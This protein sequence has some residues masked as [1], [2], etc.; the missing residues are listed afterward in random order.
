VRIEGAGAEKTTLFMADGAAG[1]VINAPFGWVQISGLTIDGNESKR[2]GTVG[3]NIR[4]NGDHVLIEHVR[5]INSVSYG[6][7]IGQK[8]YAREVIVRD[9]EIVNAGADGIDVKNW[10]KRT[11]GI[12][13][14]NVTVR[15]FGRPDPALDPKLI[16]TTQDKR[17]AKA[18]V[19]LRGKCQVRG[20]TIIG[21]L[22]HR[23]G[24][25]FRF[26]EV[27]ADGSSASH[28]KVRGNKGQNRA[29]AISV[30]S[31]DI[32]LEDVDIADTTFAIV[33]VA[34]NLKVVRGKIESS[35]EAAVL[36]R[37]F[38]DSRPGQIEFQS[39]NFKGE[40]KFMFQ[41]VDAV[42]FDNCNFSECRSQI[43]QALAQDT[44]IVLKGCRFDSA[45]S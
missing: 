40:A 14:E 19:D 34:P 43:Q 12:V 39:I 25:R 42:N 44:R 26:G 27:G 33:V 31:S 13:I 36:A 5:C 23:D 37:A 45:C 2:R 35:A 24:L 3:H 32:R 41:D 8:H 21:I 16:G 29:T 15:G 38:R 4:V 6:I 18:A 11:E 1:H 10:L 17:G 9:V 20:L 28:I 30:G 22:P 7:A